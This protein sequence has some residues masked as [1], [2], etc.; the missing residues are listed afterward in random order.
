MKPDIHLGMKLL[1]CRS[2]ASVCNNKQLQDKDK[3]KFE[4]KELIEKGMCDKEFIWNAG[5]CNC[6]CNKLCN[7]AEYLGHENCKCRKTC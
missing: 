7:V 5:N 4:C 1:K 3:C 6:E 2:D